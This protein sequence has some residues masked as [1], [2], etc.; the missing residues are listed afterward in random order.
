[1]DLFEYDDGT[2][3]EAVWWRKP[4][5]SVG[6]HRIQTMDEIRA[7]FLKVVYALVAII[8]FLFC[9]LISTKRNFRNNQGNKNCRN[10]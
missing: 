9:I 5:S 6:Y 1:M 4:K 7:D 10:G 8:I 2:K 3:F